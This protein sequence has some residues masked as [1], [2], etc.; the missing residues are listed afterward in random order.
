MKLLS[1]IKSGPITFNNRI[2]M[3]PLTRSRADNP[4]R[5]P[6]ELHA[7]HYWQRATAGLIISEGTNVSP[8]AAGY[9]H[10]PGL[11]S[12]EQVTGWQKVTARVHSAGGC[13]FTQLWHV[14]CISHPDYH[15]GKLPL[16]PSAI[17][18][19]RPIKTIKSGRTKTVTPKAM[20]IKDIHATIDEFKRAGEHAMEAG[21]DG[22]EIHSSNGYLFHQFFSTSSNIRTDHYGGSVENR[23]RLLFEVI[24]ALKTVMPEERIGARLN[25]MMHDAGSIEVNADTRETFDHIVS[26]L[27]DYRLSYLHLTRPF[28]LVENPYAVKDVI[29]H[30]RHI[31][32]GLLV[33]NGNYDPN[34]AEAEVQSGRAD[35]IA[36]GRPFISN[37]DLVNRIKNQWPLTESDDSTYYTPGP[38][39][40][41]DYPAYQSDK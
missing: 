12:K 13:I 7:E 6:T 34:E 14:G 35:A 3:A 25:P 41:T 23:V 33:A 18:P 29:G 19:N 15:N 28:R 40:Y 26:R 9:V 39:G 37:P 10:V 8:R 2:F 32:K 27:N 36:F 16:A 1:P 5:A 17:N 24:D 38:L 22:V 20:S 11:W 30:Y 21:F 4:D 31:Y